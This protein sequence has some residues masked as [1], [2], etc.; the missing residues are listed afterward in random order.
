M[1]RLLGG[2]LILAAGG[3]VW[4]TQHLERR[5][6]RRILWALICLLG[7]AEDRIRLDRVPLPA[8]LEQLAKRADPALS[9]LLRETASAMT[10]GG[11][12]AAVWRAGT[13]RLPVPEPDKLHLAA[14]ADAAQGEEEN[15]CKGILLAR[16]KLRESLAA[17]EG[18]QAEEEKRTAALCFSAAAL[19]VIVLL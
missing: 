8:L 2:S 10:G 1:I 4:L 16:E 14:L 13:V 15:I 12:P 6:R 11:D 9:P 18:R 19:L 5:Q 3:A 17:L 7:Q